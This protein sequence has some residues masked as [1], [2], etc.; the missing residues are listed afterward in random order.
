MTLRRLAVLSA[1]GTARKRTIPAIRAAGLA[2][3]AAIH[4]RDQARLDAMASEFSITATFTD[5]AAMLDAV[6]PDFAF[7][8][9]PPALHE[10]HVR[11]CLERRIPVLCE[12]PLAL[13]SA[14]A[15]DL[16]AH[17]EK[18]GVPLRIAHH[19]RFDPRFQQARTA[20]RGGDLGAV[21]RASMEWSFWLSETAPNARWKLDPALGGPHAFYD[22]GVHVVDQVLWLLPPPVSVSARAAASRFAQVEDDVAAEVRCGDVSAELRAS[23][24]SHTPAN[25]LV[26][27]GERA[28]LRESGAFAEGHYGKV[29]E[30]FLELLAG[31]R[32]IG[33]TPEEAVGALHLLEAMTRSISQGSA[34]TLL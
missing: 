19:L 10:E 12:K 22:A 6:R 24:S 33:T 25:D 30:D 2:D 4:G 28:T 18:H 17:A 32:S 21:R 34:V 1:T 27:E 13:S 7:V 3:V 23:W 14:A 16:G 8:A 11:L 15:E 26:I 20:L 9:S 31:R 5:P 29:V